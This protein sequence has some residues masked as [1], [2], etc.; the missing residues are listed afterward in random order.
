MS[1]IWRIEQDLKTN[2][3]FVLENVMQPM[4][5]RVCGGSRN[6]TLKHQRSGKALGSMPEDPVQVV[7]GQAL[8]L[9]HQDRP[10]HS[11]HRG[12]QVVDVGWDCGISRQ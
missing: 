2:S 5:G 3:A 9:L 10:P 1:R 4:F 11:S 7:H 8:R 6:D 12:N